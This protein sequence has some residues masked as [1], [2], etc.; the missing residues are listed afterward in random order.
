VTPAEIYLHLLLFFAKGE[1]YLCSPVV[2]CF[3]ML[4]L[5]KACDVRDSSRLLPA[6]F[7]VR[8]PVVLSAVLRL[9]LPRQS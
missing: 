7:T 6:V 1:I 3:A 4:F 9:H 5:G 8:G 2:G